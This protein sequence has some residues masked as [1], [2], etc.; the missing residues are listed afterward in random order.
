MQLFIGTEEECDQRSAL[1]VIKKVNA[2]P[3]T[4]LGLA[5]GST[6]IG[7]YQN[8]VQSCRDGKVS[9]SKVKTFN[10]DEYVGLSKEHPCS[11]YYFMRKYLFKDIDIPKNNIDFLDGNAPD[12]VQECIRYEESIAENG[13][14]DLQLL[15]MGHN[16]H[17][18]F[19]EPDT[20]FE[21]LTHLVDLTKC[22]I[23]AN[24][25]FFDCI[26]QVPRKA[27]T[28]GIKTIMQAKKILFFVKG[29][30]KAEIVRQV[31]Q[32]PVTPKIPA[33]ILQLHPNL[34]VFL[35]HDAASKLE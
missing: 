3:N 2:K 25:R 23:N 11:Y 1:E 4:V 16:G 20:P 29:L 22:T 6:P 31:L 30:E 24:A 32:G 17:V 12:P 35:D 14:I 5:T 28:M 21:S 7:M 33:S 15:G 13:G 8:M 27:L 18:G 9:F 10:L 26:D 34:C 19:N